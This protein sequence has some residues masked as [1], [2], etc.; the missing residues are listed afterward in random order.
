MLFSFSRAL[1]ERG[2]AV[3]VLRTTRY[4]QVIR[5]K[6]FLQRFRSSV[7][8]LV[9]ALVTLGA[10]AASPKRVLILDP[11]GRDVPP[12]S[13]GVSSFRTTL[14]QE[15][16][17]TLDVYE[18]PL[19]LMRLA[20][21]E[22]EG[23]F[24]T[25]LAGQMQSYPVDLVV[26]IGLAAVQFT[27]R[28]RE[29]LFQDT[30]ILVLG[31][32]RQA[33]PTTLL[34]TNATIV[35]QDIDLPGI[36][37]D[38]LQVRPQ[39]TN[40][41]VVAG[42]SAL[43]Q[44]WVGEFRRQFQSFSNRVEFTWLNNL[45]LGQVLKRCAA[46]PPRSF[47][48]HSYFIAGS[49]GVPY[50][51]NEALRRLCR[52]ANAP[53]F[54]Y[55]SN[56]F[57]LGPIG[58]HL[59]QDAEIGVQGA[60]VAIRILRGEKPG[61]IPP[62]VLEP[63]APV[64]DWREL[65]RWG[66]REAEL[67]SGGVVR[68]R[69]STFWELYRWRIVGTVLFCLL[70][71][72]LIIGLVTNALARKRADQVL[73]ESEE[74]MTLAAEAAQFGV[75]V[76]S[77][78]RNRVWG[79]ERW[80]ELFGLASGQDV[81]FE[82]VIQRIHPDDR[83]VVER[84]VRHALAS[85]SDYA[86]EFRALL[87][88]GSQRWIASRGRVTPD[89]NGTPARMMGAAVD[90][91][92]A[93]QSATEMQGLRLQLWHMDRVAHTGAIT[94]SLA[95]ELNQPLTGILSTA[96]AGLRFTASGNADCALIREMLSNIVHDTK[97][98]AGVINGLRAMLGRKETRR[99]SIDLAATTQEVLDLV[100]SELISRQ[101]QACQDLEPDLTVVADKGQIQQVLLNLVMNALEA[102]QDQP[103]E[104]RH[105]KL[106][107]ARTETGEALVSLRD[108]GPGVPEGG[109]DKLF[110]AFWTTKKQGMGIGLAVSRSII[111]SHGGRLWFTNNT[112][113]GA[114]FYFSFPA[115]SPSDMQAFR[116]GGAT[117]GE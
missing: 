110:E 107:L 34:Q 63:P 68:F 79:S 83:D 15:F 2:Q 101:V 61:S 47:I 75:W 76:W 18:M 69:Q 4:S 50:E 80:R 114:T 108:S 25:F 12:F 73:R 3:S 109:Q 43:E 60:R 27:A 29:R 20:G 70:Q 112:D 10:S 41:V 85:R 77:I 102:M 51:K 37:E 32:A 28:H 49:D 71:T 58:G 111:E 59:Y 86:G 38:I 5:S 14:A 26:P 113:R 53:V 56:E 16:G 31:G 17:E 91:S 90:I 97:R 100:H 36:V 65:R 33:M 66:I 67:P 11:Y 48:L 8:A 39:T 6:I 30:P 57:G 87:P 74:R 89:A 13:T 35:T 22:G 72:A 96:Q 88:D 92:E 1:D 78:A 19:E 82:E 93:K 23:S 9:L 55:F 46:L 62:Q 21:A 95:H 104:Q 40:I 115:P 103:A 98:A 94:A 106:A 117:D 81:S 99:G 116:K 84:E 42:A 105:L 52:A 7:A 44:F 45:P 64:Y 54:S 24:V